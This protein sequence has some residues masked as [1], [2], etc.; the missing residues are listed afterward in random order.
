MGENVATLALGLRPRQG[1]TKMKAK[2]DTWES[3]FMFP[4]VQE[5]AREWIGT[6]PSELPLWELESWWNPKFLERNFKGQNQ[7]DL[8]LPYIIRNLLERKCLKWACM[9]HLD[10]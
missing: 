3:H 7:L 5:S 9:T 4:G 1:L 8:G 2:R 10:T 6:L